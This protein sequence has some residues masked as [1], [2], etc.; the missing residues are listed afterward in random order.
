[1]TTHGLYA[2]ITPWDQHWLPVGEGHRVCYQQCGNPQGLPALLLHG[3]PGS[4]ISPLL[5]RL[6]DAERYRIIAVDQRGCGE[7][8]PAGRLIGNTTEALVRDIE[9]LRARLGIARWLVMGG[10]WGAALAISWAGRHPQACLGALLRAPFLTGPADL[11]WFFDEAAALAP[12]A[13]AA[14]GALA[15]AA[16]APRVWPWLGEALL[17]A[18]SVSAAWPLISAWMH[19][20]QT[21]S[22]APLG[23]R[24]L[25]AVDDPPARRAA[26]HRYRVQA[27][28][29]LHHCFLGE[30]VLLAQAA[31]L[32]DVPVALLHGTA[33]LVCRPL[34]SWRLH[35][36][37][38]QSSLLWVDGAGHDLTAPAMVNAMRKAGEHFAGARRWPVADGNVSP[39]PG[40]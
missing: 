28:Y 18:R 16:G 3:G 22:R 29:L 9:Q 27:H 20:E 35:Q 31:A 12:Q 33:D 40:T 7:S 8:T 23:P 25:L 17:A 39:Q 21:L 38:P 5:L 36:Q 11:R 19:W 14:L 37:L 13:W 15:H 30:E 24:P 26:W 10:S 4:R 1:M 6:L 34:N 32:T 2:P